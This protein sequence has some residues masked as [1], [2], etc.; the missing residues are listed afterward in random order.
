M[1]CTLSNDAKYFYK[2]SWKY[3]DRL[4]SWHEFTIV[5]FQRGITRD[6]SY[7]FLCSARRLMM[8]YTCMKFREN[9]L[10]G[11]QFIERTRLCD[12]QTDR[13]ASEA[14][15]ICLLKRTARIRSCSEIL[16]FLHDIKTFFWLPTSLFIKSVTDRF[17]EI[18]SIETM[19]S[20]YLLLSY[21]KIRAM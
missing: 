4:W 10:K 12:G 7:G 14:Q 20:V 6:K 15:T 8:L 13:Q 19:C 21:T 5:E 9:I 16:L 2:V 18:T 1:F 3:L 11:L 17:E